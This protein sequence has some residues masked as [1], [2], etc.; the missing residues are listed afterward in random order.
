MGAAAHL[1][2]VAMLPPAYYLARFVLAF[3]LCLRASRDG[4]DVTVELG[5]SCLRIEI[6]G[7]GDTA[8][9]LSESK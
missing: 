9:H 5:L 6:T 4:T 1:L 3:I 7:R 2:W 8:G